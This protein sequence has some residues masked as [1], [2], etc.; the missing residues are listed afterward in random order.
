MKGSVLNSQKEA[1]L[2][3]IFQLVSH[4]SELEPTSTLGEKVP[5]KCTVLNSETQAFWPCSFPLASH[6][7][8]VQAI[9]TRT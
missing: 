5:W 9:S 6:L 8:E 2:E 4:L 7:R 1:F 3:C